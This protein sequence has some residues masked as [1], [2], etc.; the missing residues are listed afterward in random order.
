MSKAVRR[1]QGRENR[2]VRWCQRGYYPESWWFILAR[3]EHADCFSRLGCYLVLVVSERRPNFDSNLLLRTVISEIILLSGIMLI[4]T[5]HALKDGTTGCTP[6]RSGQS[7][8]ADIT[9]SQ[10]V[11]VGFGLIAR[12]VSK[13][14]AHFQGGHRRDIFSHSPYTCECH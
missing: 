5:H 2:E 1:K 9:I 10:T 11:E 13:Q 4:P 12:G 14:P 3:E 7:V 6:S 8:A